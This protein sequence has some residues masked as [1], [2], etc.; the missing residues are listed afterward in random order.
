MKH[1]RRFRNSRKKYIL[2]EKWSVRGNKWLIPNEI[3]TIIDEGKMRKHREVKVIN[4]KGIDGWIP[5]KQLKKR[6]K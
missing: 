3:V 5:V 1:V 2:H 6:I 4:I